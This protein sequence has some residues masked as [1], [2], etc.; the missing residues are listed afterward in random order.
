[1]HHS[2]EL[3]KK[4]HQAVWA[5]VKRLIT[6]APVLR[7]YDPEEEL[8]I[9][10][11][12][13]QIGL[14]AALLQK[15]QP[16]SVASRV[17]TTAEQNYAQIEKENRAIVYGCE[18]FDHYV[19][20]RKVTVETDHKPLEALAKKPIYTVPKRLQRTMLRLQ[21]YDRNI[22]YKKGN[23]LY[24]TDTLSRAYLTS[25]NRMTGKRDEEDFENVRSVE[26]LDVQKD[27]LSKIK[28][29]TA[30]DDFMGLIQKGGQ[31]N[32]MKLRCLLI[33]ISL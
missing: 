32:G 1:M 4:D 30:E 25:P 24:I 31:N 7:Y 16:V 21:K 29:A 12:A 9:Q 2:V 11:D 13:S 10:C 15:G 28:A 23:T 19:Y 27:Q 3:E 33:H 26:D 22:I 17:L 18:R 20:G 8:T 14:G 6:C 5:E